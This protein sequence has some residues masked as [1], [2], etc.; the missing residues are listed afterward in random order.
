MSACVWYVNRLLGT[1]RAEL[2]HSGCPGSHN[3]GQ[4]HAP[5]AFLRCH[6][7]GVCSP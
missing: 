2:M 4:Q 5:H 1:W 6:L 3:D 7:L